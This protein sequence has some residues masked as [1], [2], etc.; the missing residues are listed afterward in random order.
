MKS[1]HR[2]SSY[3]LHCCYLSLNTIHWLHEEFTNDQLIRKDKDQACSADGN[4]LCAGTQQRK[5][6]PA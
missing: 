5:D 6:G 1:K 3:L 2:L 4:A